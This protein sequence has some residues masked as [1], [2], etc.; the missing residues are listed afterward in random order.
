MGTAGPLGAGSPLGQLQVG[1]GGCPGMLLHGG[2]LVWGARKSVVPGEHW[3][4]KQVAVGDSAPGMPN[5]W[6]GWACNQTGLPRLQG[7]VGSLLN[8]LFKHLQVQ[9]SGT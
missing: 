8:K 6:Y 2:A 3:H 4:P 7:K 5:P 9:L 1:D